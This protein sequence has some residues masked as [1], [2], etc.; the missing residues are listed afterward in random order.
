M[1]TETAGN[2]REELPYRRRRTSIEFEHGGHK[3]VGGAGYFL[4]GAVGEVFLHSGKE[5]TQLSIAMQDSAVAASCALQRGATVSEMAPR[6]LRNDD[7]SAAGPLG[8]LFDLLA[9]TAP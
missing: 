9:G 7:G 8:H 6:F 4:S 2:S 5:G 3:F 1:D